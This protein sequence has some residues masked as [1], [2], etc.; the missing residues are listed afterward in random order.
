MRTITR[1]A[2]ALAFALTLF[3]AASAA[4]ASADVPTIGGCFGIGP[5]GVRGSWGA[6]W[7]SGGAACVD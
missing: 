2:V 4:P 6:G 3:G 7:H 1:F 5:G